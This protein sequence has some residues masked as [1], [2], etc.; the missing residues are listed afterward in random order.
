MASK[1]FFQVFK[2][3]IKTFI[4]GQSYCILGVYF[5]LHIY[6]ISYFTDYLRAKLTHF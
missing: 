5:L 4:T 1:Q 6:L 2:K 3:R